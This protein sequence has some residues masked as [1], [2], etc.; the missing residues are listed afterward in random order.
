MMVQ[1]YNLV[2]YSEYFWERSVE[3]HVILQ[4]IELAIV[5]CTKLIS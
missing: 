1:K 4:H 5:C 3:E 2:S